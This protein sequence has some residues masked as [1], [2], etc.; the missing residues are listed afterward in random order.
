MTGETGRGGGTAHLVAHV[1][2]I[3]ESNADDHVAYFVCQPRCKSHNNA[4]SD[5]L[6][7]RTLL[8]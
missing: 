4:T 6:S 1:V 5:D 3:Y 8:T 7:D 2:A